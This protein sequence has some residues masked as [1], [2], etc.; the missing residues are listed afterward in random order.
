MVCSCGCIEVS[1]SMVHDLDLLPC[2]SIA[3]RYCIFCTKC[4][5]TY[6]KEEDQ[7]DL[8]TSAVVGG[9]GYTGTDIQLM[10]VP[11]YASAFVMT[12]ITSYVSDRCKMRG[13]FVLFWTLVAMAGYAIWLATTDRKTL[14]GALVLQVTGVYAIAGIFGAWNCKRALLSL[15]TATKRYLSQQPIAFLQASIGHHHGVH[16]NESWRYPLNLAVPYDRETSLHPRHHDPPCAHPGHG[17]PHHLQFAVPIL[18]EQEEGKGYQRRT[19]FGGVWKGRFA[20]GFQ[21]YDL[22]DGL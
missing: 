6:R 14:Y 15:A 18:H 4:V 9:L 13:P 3:V 2:R 16:R 7:A 22:I 17:S 1:P 21:V 5:S 8:P 10:S 20:S 11:P 19:G 12:V